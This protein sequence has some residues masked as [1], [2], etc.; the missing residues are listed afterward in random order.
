MKTMFTAVMLMAT[1]AMARWD[2]LLWDSSRD[3]QPTQ[4]ADLSVVDT[5]TTNRTKRANPEFR[6][7]MASVPTPALY[8]RSSG[9]FIP[10][11]GSIK[12]S[13]SGATN[14]YTK[15]QRDGLKT[16]RELKAQAGLAPK[17]SEAKL[18][19]V[20]MDNVATNT[21]TAS[22]KAAAAGDLARAQAA[23]WLVDNGGK[24]PEDQDGAP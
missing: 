11:R 5:S 7:A 12:A 6:Q 20:L 19:R 9:A 10:W 18:V 15:A 14:R 21:G 2:T 3:R 1:V 17:A 23:M 16:L 4:E 8:D 22:Q 13:E 24:Q